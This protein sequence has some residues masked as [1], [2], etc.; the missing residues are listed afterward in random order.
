MPTAPSVFISYSHKDEVWKD[1]LLTH[2][3][4]SEKEGLLELWDDRRISAGTE[5]R[6]EIEK[7]IDAADIGI[8]LISADFLVSDFIRGEEIPR[9]LERRSKN[10]MRLFP[11]MV[12]SCD[13]QIVSWLAP[14][15][16]RP[17]GARPLADFRGDRRDS[18]MAA[19][20]RG[21]R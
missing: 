10:G 2:L 4:I 11:V 16:I 1:R 8:L 12:R 13:W 20:G 15:Q 9:M 14:I 6:P 7:A 3:R 17:T 21:R 18:E 5:W 19:L